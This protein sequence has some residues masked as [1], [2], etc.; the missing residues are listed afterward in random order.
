MLTQELPNLSPWHHHHHK[1]HKQAQARHKN[2]KHTKPPSKQ[3][4]NKQEKSEAVAA[5]NHQRPAR[6]LGLRNRD[7]LPG[8]KHGGNLAK[9][10]CPPC[11]S[12]EA[13]RGVARYTTQE[14]DE[15]YQASG[16]YP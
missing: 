1:M 9:A 7:K 15:P 4:R 6:G 8:T 16:N 14:R 11:N 10:R 12:Q 13:K 5:Q 2:K 3:L